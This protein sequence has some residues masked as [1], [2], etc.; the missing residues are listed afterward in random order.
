KS[1]VAIVGKP[2]GVAG[3]RPVHISLIGSVLT[4]DDSSCTRCRRPPTPAGGTLRSKPISSFVAPTTS[5]P[6][7]RGTTYAW[8]QRIMRLNAGGLE[9]KERIWPFRGDNG[10]AGNKPASSKLLTPDATTTVGASNNSVAVR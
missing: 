4:Y 2:S 5:S 10:N 7:R 9:V 1:S 3:R 8:S 6:L